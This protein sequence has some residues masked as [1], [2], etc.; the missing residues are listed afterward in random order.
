MRL[1]IVEDNDEVRE[2]VS[3]AVA[4]DGHVILTAASGGEADAL[5]EEEAFDLLILD[6]GLPDG[7]GLRICK[8][9]RASGSSIP[10]LVLTAHATITSKVSGLDAGADDFLGKPFAVAELRARVR[11]LLRRAG[12]ARPA[13]VDLPGARLD[14]GAKRAWSGEVE[15]PLTAR[16]WALLELLIGRRGRIVSRI[17]ILESLWATDTAAAAASLDVIV[18]RVRKKLGTALVRTIRGEG[19]SIV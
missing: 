9:L 4:K 3:K 14:F 18:G 5:L 1:L 12:S 7:D 13:S 6:L 17:E 19:Y 15:V 16:E 8:A 10:I 2:L 11:A